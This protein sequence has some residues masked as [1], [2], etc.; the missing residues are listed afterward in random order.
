MLGCRRFLLPGRRAA[1]KQEQQN[2]DLGELEET[3][4]VTAP[5]GIH[6]DTS[7]TGIAVPELIAGTKT[8]MRKPNVERTK[9]FESIS[10]IDCCTCLTGE[11]TLKLI[12]S[13]FCGGE[14]AYQP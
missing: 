11:P 6:H 5:N 8:E 2:P 4:R 14:S 1:Q 3:A 13:M 12:S 10:W 9:V 7:C